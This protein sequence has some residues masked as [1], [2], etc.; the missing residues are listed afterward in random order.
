MIM[1]IEFE[2][3]IQDR[4]FFCIATLNALVRHINCRLKSL[5][6]DIANLNKIIRDAKYHM[7]EYQTFWDIT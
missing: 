2:I 7:R 4:I 3:K 5:F 6:S 1:L